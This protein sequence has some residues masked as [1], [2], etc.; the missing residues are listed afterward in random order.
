VSADIGSGTE[1]AELIKSST[2]RPL[3]GVV[4]DMSR[5]SRG[6][7]ISF[8]GGRT[9]GE[10]SATTGSLAVRSIRRRWPSLRRRCYR[11]GRDADPARGERNR[12]AGRPGSTYNIFGC[13][14]V[15]RDYRALALV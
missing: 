15:G 6:D 11:S 7:V 5:G 10:R 12:K 14:A 1:R 8:G 3:G 4:V 13:C 9:F 2:R